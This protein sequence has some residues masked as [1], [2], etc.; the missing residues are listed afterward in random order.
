[1][2]EASSKDSRL[3]SLLDWLQND[4]DLVIKSI[5]P[6]SSDASFR[7]YFRVRIKDNSF[8]VMDA[9]PPQEDVRPFIKIAKLFAQTGINVPEVY[10]SHIELGFLLL[11]D[12]GNRVYLHQL[13]S[14]NVA[15]LYDAALDS[16]VKLQQG[17][18]PDVAELPVYDQALLHRELELFKQWFLC[19]LLELQLSADNHKTLDTTWQYLIQSALEQPQVCV[20]RD[21]HSR[22]LMFTDHNNPGILDFQDA[23]IG[24]ISYDFVSLVRDCYISWP[25]Q[26][27]QQWSENYQQQLEQNTLLAQ[28]KP[29]IFKRW[30]DWM[31]MQRHLKAIGIFSRLKIRDGKSAYLADIPRTL[32]YVHHVTRQYP[33][34]AE[35]MDFLE[36]KVTPRLKL[37]IL[38]QR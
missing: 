34:F 12:L 38:D 31:G 23:M 8:I 14:D 15:Q 19:E 21:Y 5:Q 2:I 35:F 18:N 37:K 33:Q 27:V 13:N 1:M 25:E 20:H 10:E 28:T 7:R 29:E 36:T 16:L 17:I 6:A 30:V 4:L 32:A 22:N 26:Q 11:S 3:Q 24:P 9:P